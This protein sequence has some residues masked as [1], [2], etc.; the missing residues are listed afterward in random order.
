ME[1]FPKTTRG[2]IM[3]VR[4]A[5]IACLLGLQPA[6]SHEP[7]EWNDTTY[8][9]VLPAAETG[10]RSAMFRVTTAQPGGP[11]LHIHHDADEYFYV[12][13]GTVRFH[14]DGREVTVDGGNAVFVPRGSQHSYRVESEDG[15]DMLTMVVPGGFER[16]FQEMAI[17]ALVIPNDMPRI[18]EI[19]EEFQ[20]E[21]TGP[22]LAE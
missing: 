14:I 20:L 16:F 6:W 13:S 10:G 1:S 3:F 9:V 22:P 4:I 21:F 17:E 8:Q 18:T 11:P 12:V 15:A 5:A 19:A 7:V 2:A